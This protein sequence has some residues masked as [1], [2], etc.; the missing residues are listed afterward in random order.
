MTIAES[1]WPEQFSVARAAMDLLIGTIT[2]QSRIQWTMTFGTIEARLMPDCSF[3]QLLFGSE[4]GTAATRTSLTWCCFNRC[5]IRIVEWFGIRNL[6]IAAEWTIVE[7]ICLFH[8]NCIDLLTSNHQ[9]ARIQSHKR[10]HSHVDPNF[11]HSK[12]YNRYL[13]RGHRKR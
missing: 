9:F 10:N 13:C 1:L 2:S 8:I 5:C 4:Y 7:I 6:F 3:G 11:F 12:F